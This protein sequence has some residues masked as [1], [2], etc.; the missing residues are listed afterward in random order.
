VNINAVYDDESRGA[1][2]LDRLRL[3]LEQQRMILVGTNQSLNFDHVKEAAILQFPEHRPAP[4]VVYHKEFDRNKTD[5]GKNDRNDQQR[6]QHGKGGKGSSGKSNAKDKGK[7]NSGP[8]FTK[9]TYLTEIPENEATENDGE[10]DEKDNQSEAFEDQEEDEDQETPE[11]DVD[12]DQADVDLAAHCLTVT[13]RRLAG[14]KLGRKFSGQGNKSI[15][16]RKA[17]SHCSACGVKGHWK[18]DPECQY[19]L[20][21]LLPQIPKGT[22]RGRLRLAHKTAMR[23][24]ARS[25]RS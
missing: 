13:A 19:S 21:I 4:F 8:S 20:P 11:D 24:R 2:L 22:R 15:A 17:D 25:K 1:R 3:S 9:S 16:Q 18:G 12:P 7:G 14:L 6:P 5:T 23:A 10:E